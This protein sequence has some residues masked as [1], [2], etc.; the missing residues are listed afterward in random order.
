MKAAWVADNT[1]ADLAVTTVRHKP[2]RAAG[3][4]TWAEDPR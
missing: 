2:R 1:I 4:T 3:T